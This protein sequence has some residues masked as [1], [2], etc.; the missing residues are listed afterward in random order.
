MERSVSSGLL[1]TVKLI[2]RYLDGPT[3]RRKAKIRGFGRFGDRYGDDFIAVP[4]LGRVFTEVS[5]PSL[6]FELRVQR[7]RL[8]THATSQPAGRYCHHQQ[9]G[10]VDHEPELEVTVDSGKDAE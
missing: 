9:G 2:I 4:G 8:T 7:G 6:R 5:S 1:A 3:T 10:S